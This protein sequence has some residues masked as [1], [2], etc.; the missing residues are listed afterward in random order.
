M[1]QG[2]KGDAGASGEDGK[3]GAA[4]PPGEAGPQGEQGIPGT[5]GQPVSYNTYS[6]G[7]RLL[8][9]VRYHIVTL[10]LIHNL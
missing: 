6:P 2:V 10:C 5:A 9:R 7:N 1:S 8:I 4:G 3:A